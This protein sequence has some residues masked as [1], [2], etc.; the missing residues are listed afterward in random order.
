MI[1]TES[2]LKLLVDN[3]LSSY[4]SKILIIR[5]NNI[6]LE[7]NIITAFHIRRENIIRLVEIDKITYFEKGDEYQLHN[8]LIKNISKIYLNQL[9]VLLEKE[10]LLH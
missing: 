1:N 7:L 5:K 2:N 10:I 3:F 9:Q 6:F 8:F 4:D